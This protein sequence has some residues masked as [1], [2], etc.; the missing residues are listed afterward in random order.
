MAGTAADVVPSASELREKLASIGQEHLLAFHD[1]LDASRA[2]ALRAQ[3]AG[4]ELDRVPTWVEKYVKNKP[5]FSHDE[6]LQPAVVHALDGRIV[7]AELPATERHWDRDAAEAAGEQIIRAGEVAAFVV[8]G[9]QGSRL[10]FDGPKGKFP[11]GAVTNKPLFAIFAEG[12]LAASRRYGVTIP[13]YV[14][15]S[16]INHDETVAFFEKNHHFGLDPDSIMFFQQ[17][18][19]PSF[20][21]QTGKILLADKDAVATNPDGHGGSLKALYASG[22]IADMDRRGVRHISYFQVDNPLVRVIDPVVIGL[23]AS[24]PHSSAQMS[25]KIV[26][27]TDPAEKVGVLARAGGE[28]TVIEYSDMP[29]ELANQR[30]ETGELAY[31]AGNIAI[32][33]ISVG[34]VKQLN[35]GEGG[36]SLPFHRAEKKVAC[37]D[38]ET[39]AA[40]EPDAPNAVKLETFVFDALPIAERSLTLETDRVEEFAPI[41]N[42]EGKDSPAT[43][44]ALQTERAARWL[45]MAGVPVP[46]N[47]ENEPGCTL[48]ISPLTALTPADLRTRQDLPKKIEP[49]QSLAL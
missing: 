39:G 12:V 49:G 36:F 17:G 20:D 44:K 16:P 23:H 26:K 34:Y 8:A 9:G 21:M 11:G 18:V 10:G 33:V 4:L 29:D 31:N 27:K 45:E 37:V 1:E 24:S 32:H 6:K 30:T 48:E 40:L 2:E 5:D 46:R 38:P 13:W 42:A 41:K 22:A 15:T 14:M 47:A 35:E 3:I 25:T 28:T 43:S 19:M 7:G